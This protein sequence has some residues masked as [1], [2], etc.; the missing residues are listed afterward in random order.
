LKAL[1]I[2]TASFR[3]SSI[4]NPASAEPAGPLPFLLVKGNGTVMLTSENTLLLV[5]DVQ[6][7][8]AHAMND[9][10][11]LFK[12]IINVIN[13]AR[14][15]GIKILVTEQNPRGL[16]PT[17]PEI[18]EHLSRI[19]PIS[20]F[21]FSCCDNEQFMLELNSAKPEN[22]VIAG[23][24]S[25]ICVYQTARD[26]VNLKYN[27]QILSDAVSSRTAE[28]KQIGLQ[29]TKAVGADI[30]SVETVLFEI[31]KD[32]QKKEFKDILNIVK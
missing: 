31:V 8:L 15:L 29:R 26:L 28:N 13:G 12:S 9:K 4:K 30:T 23:I 27:V 10:E 11:T 22:I 3:H 16:G 1:L 14:V 2:I 21:S 19:E 5:V 20:K 18:Y 25:H 17:I 6:G 7:K 24:E 32:S